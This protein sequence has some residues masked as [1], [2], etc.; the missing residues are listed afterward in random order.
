MRMNR[1]IVINNIPAVLTLFFASAV[2][3]FAEEEGSI[4]QKAQENI[5]FEFK[6]S[7]VSNYVDRG[8]DVF[9]PYAEQKGKSYGNATGAWAFQPELLIGT[10]VEGLFL[11]IRTSHALEG[12][13]DKDHDQV[14]QRHKNWHAI[15]G[16]M[17]IVLSHEGASDPVTIINED[18]KAQFSDPENPAFTVPWFKAERNGLHRLDELEITFGYGFDSRYGFIEFGMVSPT[19]PN[20]RDEELSR[21]PDHELFVTFSPVFLQ[22]LSVTLNADFHAS[23]EYWAIEYSHPFEFGDFSVTPGILSGYAVEEAYNG[24]IHTDGYILFGWNGFSVGFHAPK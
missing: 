9:A 16:F 17:D 8:E 14:I 20:A 4:R 5:P 2:P 18:I 1:I 15:D 22:D 24:M 10:P 7:F 23:N 6:A 12:R 21:R 19:Y 3:L 13:K 11:N